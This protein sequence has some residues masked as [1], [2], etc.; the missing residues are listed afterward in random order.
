M[1]THSPAALREL[2]GNQLFVARR[3]ANRHQILAVGTADDIQ[4]TVRLYPEA[5]LALSVIACEGASEVG[6]LRGLDQ[7]RSTEGRSSIGAQGVVLI[8]CGGGEADR[9]FKR[10]GV[11]RALGYRVAVVRDDD[12]KATEA[13]KAAFIA[14]GGTL[15]AWREGRT[16]EDELFLSLTD[17]GVDKLIERAI[18]IH[19]VQL[20]EDHVKSASNGA[21]TLDEIRND[22]LFDGFTPDSRLILGKAARARRAGWFKSVTGMEEVARGIVG[23]DLTDADEGFQRVVTEI[24]SWASDGLR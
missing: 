21:K 10:A 17:S 22:A 9:P 12:T 4:S 16:L 3:A 19:G 2:S 7:Y 20:V 6:F 14:N 1:T 11:L 18:E 15:F 24:F 23:P 13:V 8:D 5:L